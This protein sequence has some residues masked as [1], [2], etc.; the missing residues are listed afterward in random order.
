MEQYRKANKNCK[1]YAKCGVKSEYHCHKY[2]ALDEECRKCSLVY[3]R[4]NWKYDAEGK[5]MKKC[6]CCGRYYYLNRFYDL[7][8]RRGDRVYHFKSS[9]CRMCISELG[10]KKKL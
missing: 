9:R 1:K 5:E 7:V 3:E 10:R 4:R 8:M 6:S 2:R